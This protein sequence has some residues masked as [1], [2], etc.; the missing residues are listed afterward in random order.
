MS[1]CPEK[2]EHINWSEKAEPI[3]RKTLKDLYS[4]WICCFC[5]KRTSTDNLIS[6]SAI[7]CDCYEKMNEPIDIPDCL[8]NLM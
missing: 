3:K 6:G 1:E 8:Q 2:S 5:K 4:T 7:C